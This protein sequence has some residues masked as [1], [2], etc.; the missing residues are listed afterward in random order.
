MFWFPFINIL[1]LFFVPGLLTSSCKNKF[2][3]PEENGLTYVLISEVGEFLYNQTC[4][5]NYTLPVQINLVTIGSSGS[6]Q[7]SDNYCFL[8]ERFLGLSY[9]AC[10]KFDWCWELDRD[11]HCKLGIKPIRIFDVSCGTFR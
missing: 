6:Y 4:Y 2:C 8:I 9:V 11:I 1:I 10:E 3:M 5:T 7:N